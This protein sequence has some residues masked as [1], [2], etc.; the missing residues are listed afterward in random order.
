MSS[1]TNPELRTEERQ[2]AISSSLTFVR[3]QWCSAPTLG[4]EEPRRALLGQQV[5][6]ADGGRVW[7]L[8]WRLHSSGGTEPAADGEGQEASQQTE[9]E[10][11]LL[12]GTH[13]MM[14][15]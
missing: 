3:S 10:Q 9:Q 2:E 13:T 4:A 6:P 7:E 12:L 8:G 15:I 1:R 11:G 5:E 14:E